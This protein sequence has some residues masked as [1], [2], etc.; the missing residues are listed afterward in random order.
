MRL[1]FALVSCSPKI[2][3]LKR[4]MHRELDEVLGGA[5]V[6]TA[7]DLPAP[8][9]ITRAV[10]AEAMRDLPARSGPWVRRGIKEAMVED[11]RIHGLE[12]RGDSCC[13]ANGW[14]QPRL[15]AGGRKPMKFDSRVAWLDPATQ[16]GSPGATPYFPFARRRCGPCI[17]E[18]FAWLESILGLATARTAM[19]VAL[20]LFERGPLKPASHDHPAAKTGACE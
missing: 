19:G 15:S 6:P 13:S 20:R 12:N 11:R 8:H 7:E 14:T 5:R 1:T 18:S 4:A 10:I 2:Q 3:R 17:G 16:A 9:P